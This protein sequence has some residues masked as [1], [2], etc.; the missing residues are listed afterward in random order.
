MPST[1]LIAKIKSISN[2]GIAVIGFNQAL[3]IPANYSA[4]DSEALNII[5][6]PGRDSIAKLLQILSW[7][8]ISKL[9]LKK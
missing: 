9:L 5:V 6:K 8:I 2:Q 7:E 4:I 1:K 3:L